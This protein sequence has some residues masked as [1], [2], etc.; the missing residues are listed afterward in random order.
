MTE[1]KGRLEKRSLNDTKEIRM[2]DT[3]AELLSK[4]QKDIYCKG[5]L[6]ETNQVYFSKSIQVKAKRK[7]RILLKQPK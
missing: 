6:K 5:Q 1:N 4:R 7:N 2:F 3:E